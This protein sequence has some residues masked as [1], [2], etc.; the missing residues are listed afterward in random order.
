MKIEGLSVAETARLTGMSQSAVK[1]R[2]HR[3]L[4]AL[5][6]KIRSESLIGQS[7]RGL[8]NLIAARGFNGPDWQ[9]GSPGRSPKS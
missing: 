7:C 3:G 9:A 1:V 8:R 5:A 6:A 4:K 2:V